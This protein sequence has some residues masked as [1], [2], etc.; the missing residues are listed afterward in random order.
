L[1]TFGAEGLASY[2]EPLTPQ[3]LTSPAAPWVQGYAA[4]GVY[5]FLS[6]WVSTQARATWIGPRFQN[7]F[8]EQAT[9]AQ[10]NADPPVSFALGRWGSITAG[11]TLGGPEARTARI[12]QIDPDFIGRL[13]DS[14]K[15]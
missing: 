7:L 14:L 15:R 8:L 2:G 13:P 10:L 11:W 6:T 12:S 3:N 9:R 1:G 5:S 4:T